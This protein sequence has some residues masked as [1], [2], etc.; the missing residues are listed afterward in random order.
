MMETFSALIMGT[1]VVLRRYHLN[2]DSV[3][4]R[5]RMAM[6]GMI[7]GQRTSLMRIHG[8]DQ[9]S[10]NSRNSANSYQFS[11]YALRLLHCLECLSRLSIR[12]E[13]VGFF[14]WKVN[15]QKNIFTPS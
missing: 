14:L 13:H 12:P 4:Y 15:A 11:Q 10:K 9:D 2:A 3:A 8:Q 5:T 7:F 1:I 6:S